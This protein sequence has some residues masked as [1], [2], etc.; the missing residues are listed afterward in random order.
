MIL[1]PNCKINLGLNIVSR[2]SDGY[3]NLETIFYPVPLCDELEVNRADKLSL[4]IE[5]FLIDGDIEKN[6]VVKAFRLL[7]KDFSIAPVAIRLKKNIPFGAGLGGGSSDAAYMLMALNEMF[8]LEL[9]SEG[10][11]GYASLL[12]ADCPF[13][14]R[15]T[16]VF[17]EGIGNVFSST[18]V[19]LKGKYL[20]LVKP[21]VSV[22]TAEAYRHVVPRQPDSPLRD[23]ASYPLKDWKDRV[24]NDFEAS[25][26]RL[27]PLVGEIKERLYSLGAIYASMSGS[28]SS[29]F[30]IFD[31]E[32]P[33]SSLLQY[34]FV[35]HKKLD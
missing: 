22:P 11:E 27:Y 10:L 29:V 3:H 20:L 12:G 7:E 26:F 17:A 1:Y 33:V 30:G 35:W 14:I 4:G 34:G 15:N 19:S 25:V 8:A 24:V 18:D 32:I 9:D 28:G 16:P 6:L 5:G 21:E 23:I 2:R 13:F 31:C